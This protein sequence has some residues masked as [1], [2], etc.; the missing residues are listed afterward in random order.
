MK[1]L[2]LTILLALLVVATAISLRRLIAGN[3][4]VAAQSPTLVAIGTEPVPPTPTPP[5]SQKPKLVAIGTEPVPPTPTP[6][7]LR[8]TLVA[9]GT[10]PVPP[11]PTPPP[12]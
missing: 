12:Q 5:P 9:I 10:E 7:K 6:P 11:T 8:T 1:N 4:T 2:V 3:A